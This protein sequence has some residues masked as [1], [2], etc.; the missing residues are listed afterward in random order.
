MNGCQPV[1]IAVSTYCLDSFSTEERRISHNRIKPRVF[2]VE[3]FWKLDLPM[4]RRD[5]K[6]SAAQGFDFYRRALLE[7]T[8]AEIFG[9]AFGEFRAFGFA[10]LVIVGGEERGDGGIAYEA[11]GVEAFLGEV[12]FL[13]FKFRGGEVVAE[14][15]EVFALFE[16]GGDAAADFMF[17][18]LGSGEFGFPREALDLAAGEADEGVAA[19]DGV[20]EE[21]EGVVLG[22]GGSARRR[23]G[24]GRVGGRPRQGRRRSP[25]RCRRP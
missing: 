24:P 12:E 18:E 23:R 6:L 11:D 20:V 19:F 17:P 5:W 16:G 14:G 25:R 9:D 8:G 4:E 3:D 21:G 15:E 13:A 22:E 10:S 2:S 1:S 7:V